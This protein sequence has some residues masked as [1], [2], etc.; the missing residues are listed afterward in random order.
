MFPEAEF[1]VTEPGPWHRVGQAGMGA[2]RVTLLFGSAAIALALIIAPIAER[3]TRTVIAQANA[4]FGVDNTPI[5]SIHRPQGYTIRRSVL[6]PSPSSVCII[7]N[8]GRK[9]GAC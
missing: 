7:S 8:S 1:T 3:E 5:G 4:P 6:Q 9:S 2:L